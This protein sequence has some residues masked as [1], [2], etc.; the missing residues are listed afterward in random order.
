MIN[1]PKSSL[2]AIAKKEG[3]IRDNLEKVLRLVEILRF[4]HKDKLLSKSLVLKGGTAINLTVFA[5]PRLSVDID[6]DYAVNCNRDEMLSA[7][8]EVNARVLSY[9]EIEGYRLSPGTKNPHSLDSWV[10]YYTNAG[11]NNDVIKIEINY[12]NR[13][14]VLPF[15]E[16]YVSI[17]FIG[18]VTVNVLS[19]LE[20]FAS[21][22][23]ALVGRNAMRDIYDV[24]NMI[25]NGLFVSLKERDLLR[26][27]LVFYLAIGSGFDGDIPCEFTYFPK[28]EKIN[29]HQ[30]RVQLIPVL[31]KTER[32][33]FEKAK[34]IVVEWLQNFM[35]FTD[36]EK[37]F[38][39]LFNS[40]EFHPEILFGDSEITHRVMNHPMAIWKCRM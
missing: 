33:D 20:L 21:K 12:S 8:K 32:F 9:M 23:N 24:Y 25:Q 15:V 26:K 17:D 11:G 10:F 29:F 7:R 37:R 2:D 38:I 16:R 39:N 36:D 40:G 13:C 3:F 28:I 31:R 14:H 22:I 18:D 6:L 30:I 5:M 35:Q 1:L 34:Q 4:F 19:P 27:T